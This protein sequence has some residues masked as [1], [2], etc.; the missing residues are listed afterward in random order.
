VIGNDPKLVQAISLSHISVPWDS[1]LCYKAYFVFYVVGPTIFIIKIQSHGRVVNRS[2]SYSVEVPGSVLA[3]RTAIV[4][5]FLRD[6]PQSV[7][8]NAGSVP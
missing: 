4:A 2:A 1:L 3:R 8:A 6:F 5:E 7:Q